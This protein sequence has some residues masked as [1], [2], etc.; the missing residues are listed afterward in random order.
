MPSGSGSGTVGSGSSGSSTS[1]CRT[2]CGNDS[3]CFQACLEVAQT[4]QCNAVGG[5]ACSGSGSS[6]DLIGS[7]K[8]SGTGVD[9]LI[10][11]ATLECATS[12][13]CYK[14]VDNSLLCV[15][16]QSGM[17]LSSLLFS[18]WRDFADLQ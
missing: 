5:S 7:G 2:K 14:Y 11:R 10:K 6:V 3:K 1:A 15:N 18:P 13:V 9:D 4:G 8:G 16:L 12:E 17:F